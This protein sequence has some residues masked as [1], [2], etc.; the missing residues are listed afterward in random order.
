M[1]KI[2]KNKFI[3]CETAI[4]TGNADTHIS[5]N[6]FMECKTGVHVYNK[7]ILYPLGLSENIPAKDYQEII[8]ILK[9]NLTLKEKRKSLINLDIMSHN[10]INLDFDI[11]AI[12]TLVSIARSII[13]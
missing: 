9:S 7:D 4:K 3:K 2:E 13:G 10:T 8:Q 11:D 5:E 1:S 6:E 12:S